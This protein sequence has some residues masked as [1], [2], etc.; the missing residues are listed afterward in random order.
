MPAGE[1]APEKQHGSDVTDR[2]AKTESDAVRL[3]DSSIW[4]HCDRKRN[5]HMK[6]RLN[7]LIIAGSARVCWPVH[8]E[9]L[10]GV[11]NEAK[12]TTIDEGL[13]AIVHIPIADST[14]RQASSWGWK[15]ARRGQTAPLVDLL[16][17]AAA[18]EAN[19]MLWTSDSDFDRIASVSSLQLDRIRN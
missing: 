3:I 5:T 15:L 13:S 2:E 12:W 14:W 7:A 19:C 8:T 18:V 10:I 11:K 9:L 4:I 6:E 17:A 1:G 16:I